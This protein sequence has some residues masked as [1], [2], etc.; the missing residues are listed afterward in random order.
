MPR[1]CEFSSLA[2]LQE[3]L[4]NIVQPQVTWTSFPSL[5]LETGNDNWTIVLKRYRLVLYLINREIEYRIRVRP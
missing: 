5:G 3:Y 4:S 1:I 2:L